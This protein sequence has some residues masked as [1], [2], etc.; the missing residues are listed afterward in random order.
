MSGPGAGTTADRGRFYDIGGERYPS[1]TTILAAVAKP[2]LG[3]W[4]ARVTA[5]YCADAA[6]ELAQMDRAEATWLAKGAPAR[7]RDAAAERGTAVHEIIAERIAGRP[8][9]V[10]SATAPYLCAFDRFVVERAPAFALSE[11][12]VYN[13]T[14]GYAGTFDLLVGMGGV[15]WLIDIKTGKGVYPEVAMQLAAYRAATHRLTESGQGGHFDVTGARMGA[16][17]LRGDGTYRLIEVDD[18]D[19]GA[20]RAFLAAAE[21]RGFLAGGHCRLTPAGEGVG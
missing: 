21:L 12:T 6:G 10:T 3:A 8:G 15:D 18:H 4:A 2:A 7:E 13:P 5:E 20:L 11:Q 17:H 16:L 9:V 1:V 19:G 14:L